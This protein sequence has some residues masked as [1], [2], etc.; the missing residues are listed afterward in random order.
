MKYA[1]LLILALT[2]LLL[3]C[4]NQAE[5]D[6]AE[7]PVE[8]V[9]EKAV[10]VVKP[11]M[12]V[13]EASPKLMVVKFHADWCGSCKAIQPTLEEVATELDGQPVLFTTLDFTNDATVKQAGFMA[14]ELGLSEAVNT[15]QGTG[16]LLVVDAESGEVK[17]KLT[18]TQ[19]VEE[20]TAKISGLL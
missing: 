15:N 17:E 13:T 9:V 14:A 16:F 12:E 20:M 8:T 10:K 3:S 2:T 18:K 5:S 4:G 11:K 6:S 7:A 19:S 1:Q